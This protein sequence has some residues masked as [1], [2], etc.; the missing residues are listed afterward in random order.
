MLIGIFFVRSAR[1]R[2][3]GAPLKRK[4]KM[5]ATTE[6]MIVLALQ[7]D[8]TISQDEKSRVL[9]ILRGEKRVENGGGLDRVL[10]RSTVQKIFSFK[11][12]KSVD[13]Y[14]QKG[15]FSRIYLPGSS[16]AVGYSEQSV[17]LALAGRRKQCCGE[18]LT[19]ALVV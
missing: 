1:D 14:A 15:V 11:S 18:S 8:D 16:R 12:P 10:S 3:S 9:S 19:S 4:D 17:R 5:K 13:Q 7:A 2:G 6:Q